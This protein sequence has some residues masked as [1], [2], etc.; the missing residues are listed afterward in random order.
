MYPA[1]RVL[2][3]SRGQPSTKVSVQPS[4]TA[5][6]AAVFH[7][8]WAIAPMLFMQSLCSQG[9][10]CPH[11]FS[12][13][14]YE[15]WGS[16]M[17]R[18]QPWMSCLV[19][20]EHLYHAD[21]TLDLS[22]KPHAVVQDAL[23]W[24]LCYVCTLALCWI[25]CCWAIET[26]ACT[27]FSHAIFYGPGYCERHKSTESIKSCRYKWKIIHVLYFRHIC[28]PDILSHILLIYLKLWMV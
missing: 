23:C 17:L 26:N 11:L 7:F 25:Y 20:Q 1:E 18:H 21:A 28:S 14:D 9:S 4:S 15:A 12:Q 5:V 8:S 24:H 2:G 22:E 10:C 13:W 19:Y 3:H 27:S 16:A 6:Q